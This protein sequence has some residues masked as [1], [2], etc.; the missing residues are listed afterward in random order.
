MVDVGNIPTPP[1]RESDAVVAML[2]FG[3]PG[4]ALIV[5]EQGKFY[6]LSADGSD[7]QKLYVEVPV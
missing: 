5:T 1:L 7:L 4:C 3:D 6:K 2:A